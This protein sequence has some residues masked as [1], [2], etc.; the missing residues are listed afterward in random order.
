MRE[1]S[2]RPQTHQQPGEDGDL[3]DLLQ[4]LR[5]LLQGA[6]VLTAFL[7]LLPFNQG[8]AQIDQREKWI[9]LATFLCSVGSLVFLTAPAAQHRLERPLVNRGQFKLFATRMMISGVALLSLAL[10]L[11]TL[12]VIS[13]VL[14]LQSGTIATIVVAALILFLWWLFPLLR[15]KERQTAT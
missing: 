12:L 6:Q 1:E 3:S 4:E 5:V 7:I 2:P 11:A 10:T 14:G 8:F 13:E 9:Y 15:K